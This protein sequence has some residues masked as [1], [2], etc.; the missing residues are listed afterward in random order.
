MVAAAIYSPW[1][2]LESARYGAAYW[3]EYIGFHILQRSALG[4]V[5][6]TGPLF[7]VLEFTR[8]NPALSFFTL[9]GLLSLFFSFRRGR[10]DRNALIPVALSAAVPI[11]L[12]SVSRSRIEQY[13]LPAYAPL[14]AL[15]GAGWMSLLPWRSL[16]LLIPPACFLAGLAPNW[17]EIVNPDYAPGMK[18]LGAEARQQLHPG[19]PLFVFDLYFAAAAYYSD[20]PTSLLTQSRKY[21]EDVTSNPRLRRS[22]TVRFV[23]AESLSGLL[24]DTPAFCLVLPGDDLK[25]SAGAVRRS[26]PLETKAEVFTAEDLG[27]ICAREPGPPSLRSFPHATN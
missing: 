24:R 13:M 12:F 7:Y 19:E 21:F 22:G 8:D 17:G 18:A 4:I 25:W 5:G 26:K 10:L 20:R 11:I 2:I 1:P 23:N 15:A 14:A 6:R 3:Q 9:G 16:R 27:M